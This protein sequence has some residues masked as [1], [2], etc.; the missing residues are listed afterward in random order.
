MRETKH[1]GEK[2]RGECHIT[3]EEPRG[4][5]TANLPLYGH[6]AAFPRREGA[7]QRVC[8]F[9]ERE[10]QP[11]RVDERQRAVSESLLTSRI[12]AV[13]TAIGDSGEAQRLLRTVHSKGLRLVGE[14]HEEAL[15]K[16]LK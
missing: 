16:K 4:L 1:G 11:V 5:E 15:I 14:V 2:R 9:D 13:R 3:L 8:T 12:S 7:S 10:A 6:R